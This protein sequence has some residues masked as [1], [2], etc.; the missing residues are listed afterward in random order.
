[1]GLL[2][3]LGI[4][5]KQGT[6]AR[7]LYENIPSSVKGAG[8]FVMNDILRG[9]A[10]VAGIRPSQRLPDVLLNN[11]AMQFDPIAAIMGKENSVGG[12]K[13]ALNPETNYMNKLL[14]MQVWGEQPGRT[15]GAGANPLGT[16]AAPSAAASSLPPEMQAILDSLNLQGNTNRPATNAGADAGAVVGDRP[17]DDPAADASGTTDPQAALPTISTRDLVAQNNV[18]HSPWLAESTRGYTG[19]GYETPPSIISEEQA[20][21]E[22]ASLRNENN[23]ASDASLSMPRLSIPPD[24]S[25]EAKQIVADSARATVEQE[26]GEALPEDTSA[27]DIIKYWNMIADEVNAAVVKERVEEQKKAAAESQGG[28]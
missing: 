28:K 6:P 14:N 22:R 26:I 20:D 23:E 12:F 15:G 21:N 1:M 3:E 8:N 10:S 16:P 2:E 19:T 11:R 9:D 13:G 18:R 5:P 7:S 27:D 25:P 24:I 17:P 4:I